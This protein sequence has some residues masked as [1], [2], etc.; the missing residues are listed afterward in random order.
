M[1]CKAQRSHNISKNNQRKHQLCVCKKNPTILHWPLSIISNRIELSLW[2]NLT[3]YSA[4]KNYFEATEERIKYRGADNLAFVADDEELDGNR[5]L[6]A[7]FWPVLKSFLTP[8][9]WCG[10]LFLTFRWMARGWFDWVLRTARLLRRRLWPEQWIRERQ[11]VWLL[12][13]NLHPLFLRSQWGLK[14]NW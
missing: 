13:W 9:R 12:Q 5:E 3:R 1:L 11:Q 6:Y 8:R 7:Y 2:P 10:Q 4:A 14:G